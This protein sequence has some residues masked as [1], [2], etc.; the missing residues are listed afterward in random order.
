MIENGFIASQ[1]GRHLSNNSSEESKWLSLILGAL[2]KGCCYNLVQQYNFIADSQTF[3]ANTIHGIS[4]SVISGN[5]D[6]SLDGGNTT[7][8]Y[9]SGSNI[10]LQASTTFNQ[11]IIFT[12][13][14]GQTLI[15]TIS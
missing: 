11:D 1:K 12:F 6:V 5:V 14:S 3:L 10:E 15:Q 7:V 8:T 2:A 9:P 13:V 4:F